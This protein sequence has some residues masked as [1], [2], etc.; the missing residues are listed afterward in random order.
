MAAAAAAIRQV[1][2]NPFAAEDDRGPIG[3]RRDRQ[4]AGVAEQPLPP[5]VGHRHA[6]EMAPV[7]VGDAVVARQLFV[8]ERVVSAQ[9]LG[10]RPI[11][12]HLALEEQLGLLHHRLA[13][14][15]VEGRRVRIQAL[16]VAHFEPLLREVLD[17][18]R[19]AA[20]GEQAANLLIQVPPQ[21]V[22]RGHVDELVVRQAAPE[23][24]RQPR[25]EFQIA[26]AVHRA[27]RG[28]GRLAFDAQ[29]ELRRR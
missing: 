25:G 11:L 16:Q 7:D 5:L 23:E 27:A 18:P 6:P 10:Q 14:R 12:A 28:G 2:E 4:D 1:L 13:Q 22:L 15:V 24:E 3:V 29:Q 26:Q 20:I 9:Q 21:L 19:R 17:E 8:Q